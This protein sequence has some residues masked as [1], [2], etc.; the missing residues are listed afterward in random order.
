MTEEKPPPLYRR[1]YLLNP[2]FQLKYTFM[3]IAL[4]AVVAGA[5]GTR[6]YSTVRENS[7]LIAM[8]DSEANATVQTQLNEQD[9]KVLYEIFAWLAGLVGAIAVMGILITHKVA[10]PALVLTRNLRELADGRMPRLRPLRKND[11]LLDLFEALHAAVT[12]IEQ[13]AKEEAE[14]LDQAAEHVSGE[15]QARLTKTAARLRR[16]YQ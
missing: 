15:L 14:L 7:Q 3:F 1:K 4:A 2:R 13:E 12:R 9:R 10:G 11:E 5:L 6:L 16:Y 8:D